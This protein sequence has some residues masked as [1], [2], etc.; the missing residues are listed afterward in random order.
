MSHS[1]KIHLSM[2]GPTEITP[3]EVRRSALSTLAELAGII[4]VAVASA[5]AVWPRGDF[6]LNDD[7]DFATATWL[8]AR[9]GHFHFTVFTAVSLRAQMLWGAVWTHLL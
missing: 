1:P 3:A 4:S 9:T 8:F 7:W 6:P 2:P 5:T